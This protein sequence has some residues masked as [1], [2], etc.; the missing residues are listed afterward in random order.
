MGYSWIS[1]SWGYRELGEAQYGCQEFGLLMA[2]LLAF[3]L[4][5]SKLLIFLGLFVCVNV[6]LHIY[7]CNTC[8][9]GTLGSQKKVSD[10]LEL[11]L[12]AC[13]LRPVC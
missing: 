2:W 10:P 5:Y 9:P 7:T 1:W 6:Y 13:E 4:I 3:W 11:E 12:D 8:V